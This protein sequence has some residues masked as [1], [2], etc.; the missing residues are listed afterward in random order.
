MTTE[1]AP[2]A[3]EPAGS[4]PRARGVDPLLDTTIV[5]AAIHPSI[6]VARVGNSPGDFF[7]APEV[8][9]PASTHPA[10]IATRGAP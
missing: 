7:L 6:G 3:P 1:D 10:S 9:D 5:R 4:A 8:L 2:A